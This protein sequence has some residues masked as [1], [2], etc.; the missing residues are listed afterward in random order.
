MFLRQFLALDF[1]SEENVQSNHKPSSDHSCSVGAPSTVCMSEL[2]DE[3]VR[4]LQ[5]A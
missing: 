4:R 2:R 3:A 1:N 5:C